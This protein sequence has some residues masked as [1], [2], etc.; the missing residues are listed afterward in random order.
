MLTTY[1][2]L[3][4]FNVRLQSAIDLFD[5]NFCFIRSLI[6]RRSHQGICTRIIRPVKI[7]V[8]NKLPL[9]SSTAILVGDIRVVSS[10][11]SEPS[12]GLNLD[13]RPG[14][15]GVSMLVLNS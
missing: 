8:T 1:L 15:F 5:R 4:A 14:V 11:V 9:P 12:A 7:S 13:K 3:Y 6:H 2:A 10:G